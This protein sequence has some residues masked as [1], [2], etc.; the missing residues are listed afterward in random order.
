MSEATTNLRTPTAP[1]AGAVPAAPTV[2]RGDPGDEDAPGEWQFA[3][4][5]A[6]L[7]ADGLFLPFE[8]AFA[9]NRLASARRYLNAGFPGAA[10]YEFRDLRARLARVRVGRG[11][12]LVSRPL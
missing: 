11:S 5:E 7:E 10:R 2:M 4:L 3:A 6:E 9:R 12:Y 8:I 1:A